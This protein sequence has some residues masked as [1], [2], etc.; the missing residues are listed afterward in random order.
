[1]TR[2]LFSTFDKAATDMLRLGPVTAS[3]SISFDYRYVNWSG[4]PS[5]ATPTID[6]DGDSLYVKASI[7]CGTTWS[8]VGLI[9]VANHSIATTAFTNK[10]YPLSA[11]AG[12]DV[13]IKFLAVRQQSNTTADYFIDIDNINL[14]NLTAIDGGVATVISPSTSGCYSASQPVAVSITNYGLGSLSNIPVTVV[15]TGPT[16]QTITGTYPGPLAVGA[17]ATFTVGN[18]N[19]SAGGAYTFS[20]STTLVGDGNNNNDQNVSTFTVN[21]IVNVSGP[22]AVCLGNTATLTINGTSTSYTWSTGAQTS[23]LVISPTTNTVYSVIGSAA[24]CTASGAFT[25]SVQDP[26]ITA[27]NAAACGN[28]ATATLTANG[29]TPS[30]INWYAS[31][32]ST[33]SLATGNTFTV[34]SATT[35]TYYAQASSTSTGSLFTTLAAGNGSSGNMFDIAPTANITIQSCNMHFG[36]AGVTT[37]VEVW[38]RPGSFVGFESANTGWTMAHT[39]TVVTNGTGTMTPIPGTFA[40]NVPAGQTYGLYITSVNGN[41]ITNY[42]NGTGLSNLY[43]SNGDLSLYE[44]KGGTYFGV[45]NSPRIFNGALFYTKQ[46]CTSTMTPVTFSVAAGATVTAVNSNTAICSGKTATLTAGGAVNYTWSPGTLTGSAV[47]VS[48]SVATTYTVYGEDGACNGIATTTLGVNPSPTL[49]VSPTVFVPPGSVVTLTVSGANSY[50]WNPG[51]SNNNSILV[52]PVVTTIYTVTG[53]NNFGCVTTATTSIEMSGIGFNENNIDG[54]FMKVYP[55]PNYGLITVT[56]DNGKY[57]FEVFDVAGK[58]VYSAT[59]NKP[60]NTINIRELANGMY[61]Y[62]IS[63]V[64]NNQAYKQGKLIKQ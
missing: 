63:S 36:M 60:E 49:N 17:S 11:L 58:Q 53:T 23:S 2:N 45:I 59:L 37:T 46:G 20:S 52:S 32:T 28:P 5:T 8:T 9:T 27:T 39:T 47:I 14:Y 26:T 34:S 4:Y 38:Y 35:T 19:M 1:M 62:K 24:S 22:S 42:T 43:T 13:I 51:G 10:S 54:S 25:V 31:P 64:E 3:T 55:N 6:I 16:N 40:I 21:P 50:S 61:T 57:I 15:I 18:A 56:T 30:I 41:P 7:D 29:F 33:T 44:G 12:N 48:P